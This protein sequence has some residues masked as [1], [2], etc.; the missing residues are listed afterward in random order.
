LTAAL[1]AS[2]GS[3]L[4]TGATANAPDST[5]APTKAVAMAS[6]V[7]VRLATAARRVAVLIVMPRHYLP[8]FGIE[9]GVSLWFGRFDGLKH[10]QRA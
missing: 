4:A 3:A 1:I 6:D 8:D 9:S 2:S 5:D 10:V 7:G